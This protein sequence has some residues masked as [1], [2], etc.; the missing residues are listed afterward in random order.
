[1]EVV[2]SFKSQGGV[3]SPLAEQGNTLKF[4]VSKAEGYNKNPQQKS[5]GRP[6]VELEVK[7]YQ[8]K[9]KA[10]RQQQSHDQARE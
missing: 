4:E 5:E 2:S 3:R 8:R 9:H 10:T 7:K 1:M 6:Q